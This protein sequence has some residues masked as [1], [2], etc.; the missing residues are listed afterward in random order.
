[1]TTYDPALVL[2]ATEYV[3][4]D[5]MIEEITQ[6]FGPVK[7]DTLWRGNAHL[8]HVVTGKRLMKK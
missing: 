6:E 4:H 8:V 7:L 3:R 5:I 1:M 2:V